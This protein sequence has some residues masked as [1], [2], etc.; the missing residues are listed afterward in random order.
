MIM[1]MNM[2][3]LICNKLSTKILMTK[4]GTK[5]NNPVRYVYAVGDYFLLDRIKVILKVT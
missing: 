4:Y 2:F 3:I 1:V 5:K